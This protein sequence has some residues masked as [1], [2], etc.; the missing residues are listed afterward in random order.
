M[1]DTCPTC[2]HV[3]TEQRDTATI[4][5]EWC[6]ANGKHVC[7]DDAV[8]EDVAAVLLDRSPGTLSNWRAQRKGPRSYRHGRTG[9]CKY[10]LSGLAAWLDENQSN[11]FQ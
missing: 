10:K 4:L 5:R 6:E 8:H 7:A 2:G 1:S 3:L 11:D 9:R